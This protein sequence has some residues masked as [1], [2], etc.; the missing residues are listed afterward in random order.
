MSKDFGSMSKDEYA[1]SDLQK[2]IKR[3]KLKEISIDMDKINKEKPTK[4]Q[5]NDLAKTLGKK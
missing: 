4:K 2:K 1:F 3:R 5:I